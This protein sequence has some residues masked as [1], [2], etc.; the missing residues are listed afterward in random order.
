MAISAVTGGAGFIGSHIV[1]GLLDR[2]DEVRVVDNFS[3]GKR[4]NLADVESR[5]D[6]IEGDVC[7]LELMTKVLRGADVAY[8][9]AA[10]PSVPRSVSDPLASN[11]TNV[12]GTVSVLFAAKEEG[13]RRVVYAASSAAYG[14]APTLPRKEDQLPQPL[15]PYAVAKLAGEYYCT[16]FHDCYGLETVSLRYFN[17]FGPRQ[18]PASQYAAVV[19]KFITAMMAGERPTIYGDGEQSRDF[20]YGEHVVHANILAATAEEAPGWVVNIGCGTRMTLNKLAS[21]IAELLGTDLPPAYADP[22]PG[23]VL[24]SHADLTLAEEKLGY[25]PIVDLG[26]GLERTIAYFREIAR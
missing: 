21:V 3:T 1:R 2:G 13:V 25:K 19:P 23:D 8:H 6:L 9:Q 12:G 24:H 7:D 14:D 20:T 22:R 16:A 11:Q 18:D 4:E 17:V 26:E 10:L 5:I 15:S